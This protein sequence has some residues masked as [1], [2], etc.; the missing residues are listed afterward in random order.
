MKE[1]EKIK[2]IRKALKLTQQVMADSIGV[3]KQY[4]SRVENSLTDLSKEKIVLLCNT[5]NISLNWLLM[6]KGSMFLGKVEQYK[7]FKE[8][9]SLLIDSNMRLNLFC[10][11]Y[12]TIKKIFEMEYPNADFDDILDTSKNVYIKDFSTRKLK[13]TDALS[14]IKQFDIIKE[15]EEFKENVLSEYCRLYVERHESIENLKA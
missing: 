1:N 4:L 9:V 12:K 5:Y 11:Y 7:G 2:E 6:D 10:R 8:N 14:L 13:N 15:S 3:S